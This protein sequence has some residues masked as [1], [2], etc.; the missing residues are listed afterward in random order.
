MSFNTGPQYSA[1]HLKSCQHPADP[2]QAYCG[3]WA[4]D[5]IGDAGAEGIAILDEWQDGNFLSSSLQQ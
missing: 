3:K 1:C 2:C 5:G 4:K